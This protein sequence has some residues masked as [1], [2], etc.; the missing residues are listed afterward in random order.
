MGQHYVSYTKYI[1]KS[2]IAKKP[3]VCNLCSRCSKFYPWNK[4]DH[5]KTE[6]SG[7]ST[8]FFLTQLN[9]TENSSLTFC[10][11]NIKLVYFWND[12]VIYYNKQFLQYRGPKK[13]IFWDLN[14]TKYISYP[15]HVVC[16]WSLWIT[17]TSKLIKFLI[18]LWLLVNSI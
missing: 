14:C 4:P 6:Y 18:W 8:I 5:Q 16:L 7:Y 17:Q 15:D 2:D 12:E 10:R 1:S 13:K 9:F 3:R 11:N